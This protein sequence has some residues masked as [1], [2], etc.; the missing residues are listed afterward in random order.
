M[1]LPLFLKTKEILPPVIFTILYC[2]LEFVKKKM[3]RKVPFI[4]YISG[5]IIFYT[6]NRCVT[7]FETIFFIQ[8]IV[9]FLLKNSFLEKNMI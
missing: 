4:T 6:L 5:I 7:S 9:F 8:Y 1:V 3:M 2:Q